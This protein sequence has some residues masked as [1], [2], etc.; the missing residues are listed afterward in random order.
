MPVSA[1][2]EPAQLGISA[3]VTAGRF[4]RHAADTID[5]EPRSVRVDSA[6]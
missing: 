3:A 2:I 6:C 1:P 4:G 5:A